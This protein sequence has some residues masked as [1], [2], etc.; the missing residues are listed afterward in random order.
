MK[1]EHRHGGHQG[2]RGVL[3]CQPCS[4]AAVQHGASA[5]QRGE[6]LQLIFIGCQHQQKESICVGNEMLVPFQDCEAGGP[7]LPADIYGSAHLL[8]LMVKIGGYLSLSNYN[9]HS[10]KVS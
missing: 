4:P 2:D 9:Q 8:R 6:S 10:C 3:Q 1:E 5:V 7:V